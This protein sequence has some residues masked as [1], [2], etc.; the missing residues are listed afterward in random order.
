MPY[1]YNEKNKV[2]FKVA[3]SNVEVK[4]N[5]NKITNKKITM[6]VLF[7]KDVIIRDNEFWKFICKFI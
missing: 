4:K 1:I 3:E 2:Q 6:V 5:N 7:I